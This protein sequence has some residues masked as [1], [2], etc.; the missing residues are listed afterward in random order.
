MM[1]SIERFEAV[2]E[3]IRIVESELQFAILAIAD[4]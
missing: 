3:D 1:Y 4:F 2:A